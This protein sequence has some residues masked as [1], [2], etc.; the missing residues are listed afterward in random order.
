MRAAVFHGNRDI[1]VEDVPEPRIGPGELLLEV[2]AVGVCG[3]DAAEFEHGP[4]MFPIDRSHRVT[5]HHGPLIPGHE[6]AGRVVEVGPGAD[7]FKVGD[8]VACGAGASCGK[9]QQCLRGKTNLCDSYWTVGLQRNGGLAQY[10]AVPASICID[11]GLYGLTEDVAALAQPMSIAVHSMRQGRPQQAEAV[12]VIGAG[13][14]GAFL[15]FAL[16]RSG[17]NTVVVEL[18]VTRRN[19][20][21]QLGATAVIAP[22]REVTLKEQLQRLGVQPTVVYEVS[23]TASGLNAA[24]TA[25]VL[26]GRLVVIGLQ[27]HPR[28]IDLRRLT[29]HE[30]E[31]IGTN[32][33]VFAADMPEAV[34]LLA[35]Q[36]S[37]WGSIAPVA[38]SLDR[39]VE[40]AILPMVERRGTRVKSLIDPWAPAT[41]PTEM[42]HKPLVLD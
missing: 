11:V 35:E 36:P 33:H 23:G 39:L 24:L 37:D 15:T 21:T 34:R 13:G 5:G 8:V 26:G 10:C 2:H 12:V 14:I 3:T 20:A 31:I 40:D 6:L 28:E 17:F 7:G 1:R 25:V 41:R 38:L 32:A 42:N 27:E 9:C 29:L 18:D 22:E 30:V 19:L 16:A 4:N